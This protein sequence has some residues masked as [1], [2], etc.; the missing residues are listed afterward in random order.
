MIPPGESIFLDT[1]ILLS[2][3]DESRNSHTACLSIISNAA[4]RGFHP[5]LSSQ[6][7]REYL[8]VATRPHQNNGLG[9]QPDDALA[10][11]DELRRFC[12]V[13]DDINSTQPRLERLV[14]KH[15]IRGKRIHDANIVATMFSHGVI[16]LVSDNPQDFAAFEDLNLLTSGECAE[17]LGNL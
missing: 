16:W 12:G 9:I 5:V 10:N 13:V 11:L 8:V 4:P 2:A 1:N 15:Q 7:L 14:R 17:Y 3:C 6:V